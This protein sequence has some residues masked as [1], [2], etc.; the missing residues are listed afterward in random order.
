MLGAALL[1][2][3]PLA[4]RADGVSFALRSVAGTPLS[5]GGN[6]RL[7]LGGGAELGARLGATE[8]GAYGQLTTR[9]TLDAANRQYRLGGQ[10]VVRGEAPATPWGGL[11]AGYHS[12]DLAVAGVTT[13][14][15]GW[16]LGAQF[17]LDY[18][19]YDGR[20]AAG[21]FA[22]LVMQRSHGAAGWST[23]AVLFAGVRLSI[24]ALN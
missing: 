11:R 10:V 16:E 21:P 24:A 7:L 17:G 14:S 3:A 8:I 22:E 18:G 19:T 23:E 4:A 5:H 13:T 2:L 6:R 20:F 9:P 15:S 12:S 1:V